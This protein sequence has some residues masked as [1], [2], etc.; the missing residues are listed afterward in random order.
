[1]NYYFKAVASAGLLAGAVTMVA[2]GLSEMR[3]FASGEPEPVMSLV[4]IDEPSGAGMVSATDVKTRRQAIRAAMAEP[5]R[6]PFAAPAARAAQVVPEISGCV[7]KS[8]S[9]LTTGVYTIPSNPT[10]D[11][12][13]KFETANAIAGC[14]VNGAYYLSDLMVFGSFKMAMGYVYSIETGRSEWSSSY[15]GSEVALALTFDK[16]DRLVYGLSSN[17]GDGYVLAYYLFNGSDNSVTR[18]KRADLT[19]SWSTICS[20]PN[21]T[22]YALDTE[23]RLYTMNKQSGETTLI[24]ETG[25]VSANYGGCVI[26]DD[27]TTMYRTVSNGDEGV[28]GLVSIDLSTAASTLLYEFPGKEQVVGLYISGEGTPYEPSAVNPPYLNTFDSAAS[29]DGFTIIDANADDMT[30]YY[31]ESAFGETVNGY[32]RLESHWENAG[33]DWAITPGLN[34]KGGENYEV[35]F[36]AW[37]KSFPERIEVRYGLDPNAES[38][39]FTAIEPT[40]L[41]GSSTEQAPRH[42]SGLLTPEADGVYY[43]GIHGISDAD[44]FYLNVDNLKIS[45]PLSGNVP[46]AVSDLTVTADPQG[47]KSVT[48]SF[49]APETDLNGVPLTEITKVEI[50]RSDSDEPVKVFENVAPGTQLTYTDTPATAGNYTYTVIAYNASG[51]GEIE[52]ATV[53]CGVNLPDELSAPVV[54]VED[55]T[56]GVVTVSWNAVTTDIFGKPLPEGSCTYSVYEFDENGYPTVPVMTG[57]TDTNCTFTAYE[58]S[59]QI[60]VRYYVCPVTE[61][62]EGDGRYTQIIPVGHPYTDFNETFANGATHYIWAVGASDDY[63]QVG[64]MDEISS[65]DGEVIRGVDGQIGF[66]VISGKYRDQWGALYSGKISTSGMSHPALTFYT[67]C[68]P[69]DMN[70]VIVEVKA[71]NG[72]FAKVYEKEALL[73][74]H[75]ATGWAKAIVD[76]SEYAGQDIQFTLAGQLKNYSY[77]LYDNIAVAELPDVDMTIT[78]IHAPQSVACGEEYTVS[79]SVVN[80]GALTNSDWSIRLKADGEVVSNMNSEPLASGESVTVEFPFTMSALATEPIA[81]SAEVVA[82][83]D[84]F[85]LD[86]NS[87]S[88]TVTPIV[89]PLPAVTDL[90]AVIADGVIDLTWT[91]PDLD[92]A[93]VAVTESFEDA[94]SFSA[95]YGDWVFV[96]MDGSPVGG[97][98]GTTLPNITNGQTLGSFWIWDT[99]LIGGVEAHSGSK[100]LFSLFRVDDGTSDEWAIS[101]LLYGNAQVVSFYARSFNSTYPE[102][103]EVYYSTGSTEVNDFIK[104]DNVGG[105]VPGQ[106]KLYTASLPEGA[107]RFAIRSC[108]TGAFMLMIDDVTFTPASVTEGLAVV[109]YNVY[110]DGEKLNGAPV[111]ETHYADANG[112]N[113]MT[114]RYVV[115]TVYTRGE[116]KASNEVSADFISTGIDY[117]AMTS[118]VVSVIGHDIHVTGAEGRQVAVYAVDGKTVVSVLSNGK[119]VIPV[120]SGVYIV[121]A[122]DTVTKVVVR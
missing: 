78:G 14:E 71:G 44:Q 80:N 101:P 102:A 83:G 76:L 51:K 54:I 2:G 40:D 93:P 65:N 73:V 18:F 57:I 26:S 9:S 116:S 59:G 82:S 98:S 115:T 75:G 121:K 84:A 12:G 46:A 111:E 103:I 105:V 79:V 28:N 42:L 4:S 20:A 77:M 36:D 100:F 86:N 61:S 17:G 23:G 43:V 3:T 112:E 1:M 122:G 99:N 97:F 34:L 106:W 108:A 120:S 66:A 94:E 56:P 21:G 74:S 90:N 19:G 109:G 114:Y 113:G 67:Y 33:D 62:G 22:L 107:R 70:L 91:E 117:A 11:F 5:V 96:D 32:L 30:W 25:F 58:G 68:R 55:A 8:G 110:R 41:D 64:L 52:T 92:L 35:S 49:K 29:L 81:Y 72:E 63:V 48:I 85:P 69:A 27:N 39:T 53:F 13:F 87:A 31:E 95:V 6:A 47:V 118:A 119:T 15:T 38:M 88:I 37:V 10:L 45:A 16:T 7:V 24:G 60:F 104:V 50:L 89:S